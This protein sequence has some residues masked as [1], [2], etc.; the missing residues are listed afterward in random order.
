[1]LRVKDGVQTSKATAMFIDVFKPDGT[2]VSTITLQT[3]ASPRILYDGPN[4]IGAVFG[5]QIGYSRDG[6][7]GDPRARRRVR[8]MPA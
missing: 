1:M 7:C 5:G 4:S 2:P 8:V 3:A 6:T